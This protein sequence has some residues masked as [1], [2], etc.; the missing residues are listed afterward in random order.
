MWSLDL[1]GLLDLFGGAEP[2]GQARLGFGVDVLGALG[3]RL[4]GLGGLLGV[5]GEAGQ[6]VEAL[7]DGGFVG[8]VQGLPGLLGLE[9][10]GLGLVVL[11]QIEGEAS[12][13]LE[14]CGAE[15]W[16]L[17]EGGE[18]LEGGQERGG[19]AGGVAVEFEA[20]FEQD[21]LEAMLV[22]GVGAV[23]GLVECL[24]R[25]LGF[26]GVDERGGALEGGPGL[27]QGGD[28]VVVGARGVGQGGGVVSEQEGGLA[29]EAVVGPGGGLGAE[30]V[31]LGGGGGEVL[32]GQLQVAVLEDGGGQAVEQAQ[33]VGVGAL[34]AGGFEGA[35]D[36]VGGLAAVALGQGALGH[37][38]V[39]VLAG[40]GALAALAG[41]EGLLERGVVG[42][43]GRQ[44]A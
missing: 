9:G 20:H 22:A 42:G 43:V 18:V 19:A 28:G 38:Q 29:Q 13:D 10:Q 33:S 23:E 37:G 15:A 5:G 32:V 8:V 27:G 6:G 30:A 16:G 12:L 1:G 41:L 25:L 26:V 36:V 3:G 24:A 40:L 21:D 14:G 7:A 44:G 34:G 35:L 31:D 11:A 2:A 17:G 39:D 4:E